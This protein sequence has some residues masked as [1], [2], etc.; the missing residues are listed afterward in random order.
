MR[1]ILALV[2]WF[3]R[4]VRR[5]QASLAWVKQQIRRATA[6]GESPRFLVHDND[7]I[8]GQFRDRKPRGEKGRLQPV[9]V[10]G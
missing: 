10:I 1:L 4:A 6:W 9:A 5:P 2:V 8:F 7:G 3:E